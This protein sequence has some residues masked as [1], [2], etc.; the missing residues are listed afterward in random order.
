MDEDY[1]PVSSDLEKDG[2]ELL[3]DN[4]EVENEDPFANIVFEDC[5]NEKRTLVGNFFGYIDYHDRYYSRKFS[6]ID[7]QYLNW[8]LGFFAWIFNRTQVIF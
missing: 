3:E 8:F 7:H 6:Q 5:V 1:Q 2:G 4:E